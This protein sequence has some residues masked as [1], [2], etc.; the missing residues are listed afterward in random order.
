MDMENDKIEDALLRYAADKGLED[1]ENIPT[2]LWHF[3]GDLMDFCD[4]RQINFDAALSEVRSDL[5]EMIAPRLQTS[6]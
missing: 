4:K 1:P 3:L 5:A 6:I 2:T